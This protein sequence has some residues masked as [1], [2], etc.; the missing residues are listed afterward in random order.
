[1]RAWF[2]ESLR[3]AR[4]ID[5]RRGVANA[6]HSLGQL[7]GNHGETALARSLL[8]ES[9]THFRELNER[10]SIGMALI[11][12]GRIAAQEA[13]YGE[14]RALLSEWASDV[15][16]LQARSRG[17]H[18]LTTTEA[19]EAFADLAAREG[20]AARAARLSGAAEAIR[21]S[22]GS[23]LPPGERP[24]YEAHLDALRAALGKRAFAAAWAEGRSL[25]LEQAI[26]YA[27][28][29]TG[30]GETEQISEA[31][32]VRRRGTAANCSR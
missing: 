28:A 9:L 18:R 26:E 6:L 24:L 27:L 21:E 17:W 12:L 15:P 29:E 22:V 31:R 5:D 23:P 1:A 25:T 7:A 14:A 4:E 10:L 11:R 30:D 16:L 19:L 32:R 20:S 3:L 2:E 13:S 8:E